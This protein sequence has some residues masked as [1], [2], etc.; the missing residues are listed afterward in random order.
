MMESRKIL[1]IC[2][3]FSTFI[4]TDFKILSEFGEV[5][6]FQYNPSKF[7]KTNIVNQIKLLHFLISTLSGCHLIYIWFA[8]YHSFLPVLFGRIFRKKTILVLGGYD[9][10][11]L[12]EIKYGSFNT[13][14]R[15]L[16]TKYSIS[17]ADINLCV[18][19][20]IQ[21]DALARVPRA[22]TQVLHTGY[23][24][25][26]FTPGNRQRRNRV[27]TV[28]ICETPQTIQLK[29]LDY[30]VKLAQE[31]PQYEFVFIGGV[32]ILEEY[33]KIPSNLKLIGE[34]PNH[35]LIPYYQEA[36]VYAQFSM[37]EGLP[38]CVCESMLCGCIPVGFDNGGIP[39]AIGDAGYIVDNPDMALIKNIIIE[40]MEAPEY[41]RNKARERIINQFGL[42]KRVQVIKNYIIK[43]NL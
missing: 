17:S 19:E 22:K 5:L 1:L 14:V 32:H 28:A 43:K 21:Q 40:A 41:L 11:S 2:N 23:S 4:K 27:M 24:D 30:F 26:L 34:L 6:K 38:N 18:S 31:L 9:V 3:S 16:L 7:L 37:R 8:D 29:G 33:F 36:K 35:E 15:A 42:D 25:I 10:A 13:R 20:N 12:P 39:I